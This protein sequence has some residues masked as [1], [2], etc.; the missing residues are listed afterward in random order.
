M[1]SKVHHH[2]QLLCEK[3]NFVIKA[4]EIKASVLSVA[5]LRFCAPVIIVKLFEIFFGY[6]LECIV[7]HPRNKK[8]HTHNVDIVLKELR[9]SEDYSALLEPTTG[10]KVVDGDLPSIE[11]IFELFYTVAKKKS[12]ADF[13]LNRVIDVSPVSEVCRETNIS[14]SMDS[15][16]HGLDLRVLLDQ[17]TR[18]EIT[19]TSE[20]ITQK[21]NDSQPIQEKDS[22]S[23]VLAKPK[24]RSRRKSKVLSSDTDPSRHIL[25]EVKSGQVKP[26]RPRPRSAPSHQKHAISS[27]S[28]IGRD[29]FSAPSSPVSLPQHTSI[30]DRCAVV[31]SNNPTQ[32]RNSQQKC[33]PRSAPHTGRQP[34]NKSH[35]GVAGP[36]GERERNVDT[37][38]HSFSHT[39]KTRP[40]SP[41]HTYHFLTGR[42]I[43]VKE[44]RK[45]S[46]N[47]FSRRMPLG[48]RQLTQQ[49][50]PNLPRH[51]K[52]PYKGYVKTNNKREMEM[53]LNHP[54]LNL[55]RHDL[56]FSVTRR[57]SNVEE[58]RVSTSHSCVDLLRSLV[59][60]THSLQAQA[61]VG[62]TCIDLPQ[63]QVSNGPQSS[64]FEVNATYRNMNGILC[65]ETLHSGTEGLTHL[66]SKTVLRTR[67]GSFLSRLEIIPAA[68]V[69]PISSS[70]SSCY[71]ASSSLGRYPV[72]LAIDW[73]DLPISRPNWTYPVSGPPD[74]VSSPSDTIVW[75]YDSFDPTVTTLCPVGSLVRVYHA[76]NVCGQREEYSSLGTVIS[77][78]PVLSGHL[79]YTVSLI[80]SGQ[81]INCLHGDCVSILERDQFPV[82][83]SV[84]LSPTSL[85]PIQLETVIIYSIQKHAKLCQISG[86][87]GE[88]EHRSRVWRCLRADGDDEIIM[89]SEEGAGLVLTRASFVAQI[90]ELVWEIILQYRKENGSTAMNINSM[91]DLQLAYSLPVIDS[92]FKRYGEKNN[93]IN[94]MYLSRVAQNGYNENEMKKNRILLSYHDRVAE[95]QSALLTLLYSIQ[96]SNSQQNECFDDI[97][98]LISHYEWGVILSNADYFR[99]V[100][101]HIGCTTIDDQPIEDSLQYLRTAYEATRRESEAFPLGSEAVF[102]H[103]NSGKFLRRYHHYMPC[104]IVEYNRDSVTGEI[105]SY[106]LKQLRELSQE[107][108]PG[109]LSRVRHGD[110]KLIWD[111]VLP[112]C[113]APF[114]ESSPIALDYNQRLSDAKA[115]YGDSFG[116]TGECQIGLGAHMWGIT[117]SQLEDIMKLPEYSE[118]MTMTDVVQ[119]LIKPLTKLSG[120]GYALLLNS[121]SPLQAKV[122]VS[123]AWAE[124]YSQFV[125]GLKHS[126]L[127]GPF[128][129]CAMAIYQNEDLP[130][131]TIARQ[132]GPDPLCGPFATVLKQATCM[133]AVVTESVDIYTRLWCTFEIFTAVELRVPVKLVSYMEQTG[134]G[135][136]DHLLHHAALSRLTSGPV[137]TRQSRCGNPA[138]PMN[139]DE[140]MIRALIEQIP[141]SYELLNRVIDWVGAMSLIEFYNNRPW[142]RESLSEGAYGNGG[143]H[144]ETRVALSHGIAMICSR[145]NQS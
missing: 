124:N 29:R 42:R 20:S 78:T 8:E 24:V 3:A 93:R 17:I 37:H 79:S 138:L 34:M 141:G 83:Q 39:R 137:D 96:N 110:I 69:S 94:V 46:E 118:D 127:D 51:S 84:S 87:I 33:R 54:Q 2:D 89:G 18:L 53:P 119:V 123:H 43:R 144:E 13:S 36:N 102:K 113:P 9:C 115:K 38:S 21:G 142:L 67:I 10:Q 30:E 128:W 125:N 82:P 109:D 120:R 143:P 132:L 45:E 63:L 101:L 25:R 107:E 95:F 31:I 11:S 99:G 23:V 129:V 66:P 105:H 145:L 100:L 92:V 108:Y 60:Y 130:S 19:F 6:K 59:S 58:D 90:S 122:M 47:Y 104:R 64:Y 85:I 76:P 50:V 98:S 5:G 16:K 68:G 49:S 106:H 62:V 111:E 35:H 55:S 7:S 86:S 56:V 133:V 44:Y 73:N 15:S 48:D 112:H 77:S 91:N 121:Q 97:S 12:N 81:I 4:A 1:F 88:I 136:Q 70:S 14:Q 41:S 75:V 74:A 52:S 32:L 28:T 61:R 126:H 27:H 103:E 26:L 116:F 135:G 117:L 134:Y 139:S 40:R 22:K 57:M 80:S 140:I 114:L 72:G 71:M 65:T 131:V